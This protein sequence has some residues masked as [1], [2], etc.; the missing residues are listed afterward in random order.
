MLGFLNQAKCRVQHFFPS[1]ILRENLEKK[2]NDVQKC[3][4]LIGVS[5]R[6]QY[7]ANTVPAVVAQRMMIGNYASTTAI[8][9]ITVT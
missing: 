8:W 4:H 2:M 6:V 7:F 5:L 3:M 1:L 9:F